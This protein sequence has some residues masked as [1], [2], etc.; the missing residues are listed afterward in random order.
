MDFGQTP[1]AIH[2]S[3]VNRSTTTRRVG[4]LFLSNTA[5]VVYYA[6]HV[7]KFYFGEATA[8]RKDTSRESSE[9]IAYSKWVVDCTERF[10]PPVIRKY[11]DVNRLVVRGARSFEKYSRVKSESHSFTSWTYGQGFKTSYSIAVHFVDRS[12]AIVLGTYI[13][14]DHRKSIYEARI[15][16]EQEFVEKYPAYVPE[17]EECGCDCCSIEEAV[18]PDSSDHVYLDMTDAEGK[19]PPQ[20]KEKEEE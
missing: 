5:L 19:V 6:N 9:L 10:Q 13:G 11:S 7:T 1:F 20:E 14:F 15:L 3:G 16:A 2:V 18:R 12:P 8:M 4:K 17:S